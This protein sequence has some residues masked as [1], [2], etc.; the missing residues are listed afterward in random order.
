MNNPYQTY[1]ILPEATMSALIERNI[2]SNIHST[3]FDNMSQA[4]DLIFLEK[5]CCLKHF[6]IDKF[7]M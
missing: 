7:D 2:F 4:F 1:I 3:V 5:I 6:L